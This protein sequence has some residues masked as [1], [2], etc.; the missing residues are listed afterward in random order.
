MVKNRSLSKSI[1]DASWSKFV[2][3]LTYKSEWYGKSVH[4]IHRWFASSKTCSECGYQIDKL[5]LSVREW[6]CPDCETVHDRDVN[7]AKNVLKRGIFEE[8]Q[9]GIC[10]TYLKKSDAES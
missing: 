8:T 2:S 3:I 6:A 5:D 1:S 10:K 9:M 7:A 4:K